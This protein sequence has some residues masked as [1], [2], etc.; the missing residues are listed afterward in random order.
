MRRLELSSRQGSCPVQMFRHCCALNFP[1]TSTSSRRNHRRNWRRETR[2]LAEK[3][4]NSTEQ[5]F[6]PL[7]V[8]TIAVSSF[9]S[10]FATVFLRR[11]RIFDYSIEDFRL[12]YRGPES[13]A[14]FHGTSLL[15]ANSIKAVSRG[16]YP[17]QF[18]VPTA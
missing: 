14:R 10:R 7:R 12:F 15:A 13:V 18:Q 1:G 8:H 17:T 4:P 2:N 11:S 6:R 16:E 9:G 5:P 3:R